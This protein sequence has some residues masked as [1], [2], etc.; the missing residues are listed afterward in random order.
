MELQQTIIDVLLAEELF[1]H[2]YDVH[3]YNGSDCGF[4]AKRLSYNG[5]KIIFNH[6]TIIK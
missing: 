3:V 5:P 2:C 1:Y 6:F 4:R